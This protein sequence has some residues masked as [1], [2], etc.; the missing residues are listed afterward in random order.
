MTELKTLV[1]A[2]E[3]TPQEVKAVEEL[4]QRRQETPL[5]TFTVG[6]TE[7]NAARVVIKHHDGEVATASLHKSLGRVY[8]EGV[9]KALMDLL[10]VSSEDVKLGDPGFD[11]AFNATVQAVASIAPDD[12]IEG[13]LACQ[14]AA[15]HNMTMAHAARAM[16]AS[17]QHKRESAEKAVNRLA[18]TFAVQ[19]EALKKHRSTAHQTITVQHIHV[20]DNGQAVVAGSI[21]RGGK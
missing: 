3:R 2:H 16:R 19:V 6:R 13:M 5:P 20:S 4:A 8:S 15:I 10:N 11:T 9:D 14:M 7:D 18:R 12:G 17:D 21:D 1:A